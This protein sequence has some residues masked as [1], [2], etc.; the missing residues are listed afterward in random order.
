MSKMGRPRKFDMEAALDSAVD[1]FYAK[2]Y[3]ATTVDDLT[4]AMG[5]NRPSLYATFGNKETLFLQVLN[6][7]RDRYVPQVQEVLASKKNARQAMETFLH[8]TAQWH[9]QHSQM[10]G[11][12][13]ANSSPDC[14][15]DQPNIYE[16]IQKLHTQNEEMFF[17][18][19]QQAIDDGEL[20]QGADIR[21]LAQF[22][23]GVIQGM[24]VLARGQHNP[25]AIWSMVRFAMRAW[26][27]Y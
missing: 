19:L 27:N 25:D 4:A 3:E 16:H 11:C 8:L 18:R 12:L 17:Q 26:P 21:G 7:Y 2:G 6:R 22:F 5:V 23:N 10:M 13:I 15:M 9:V 24:A 14:R 20:P 1:V